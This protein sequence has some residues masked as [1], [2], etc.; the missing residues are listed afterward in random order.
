MLYMDRRYTDKEFSRM[1]AIS[2]YKLILHNKFYNNFPR[3]FWLKPNGKKK[4]IKMMRYLFEEE[5]NWS[6]DSVIKRLRLVIMKRYKLDAPLR[7][8]FNNDLFAMLNEAYPNKYAKWMFFE[9]KH[10]IN[11]N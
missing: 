4:A 9:N 1:D 2:Q 5:L 6:S 7:L 10:M 11:I 8:F 3:G